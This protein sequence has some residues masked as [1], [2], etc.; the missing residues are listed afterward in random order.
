MSDLTNSQRLPV[1][2]YRAASLLN[3]LNRLR[4][5][6]ASRRREL[7]IAVMSRHQIRDL[8][9]EQLQDR[10]RAVQAHITPPAP[11]NINGVRAGPWR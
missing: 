7:D 4:L 10:A 5:A 9:M 2:N 3:V 1:F 11:D 6:F 8:G